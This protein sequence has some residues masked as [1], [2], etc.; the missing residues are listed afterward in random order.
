[1]PKDAQPDNYFDS[2]YSKDVLGGEEK[3]TA[4]QFHFHA[5]SEHTI[6][7]KRYDLEMHTVHAP[8]EAKGDPVKIKYSAVGLMFDTENFD[9]SISA[10]DRATIDDFFDSLNFSSIPAPGKAKGHVMAAN[11]EVPFGDLMKMVNFA[12]RWVYTGS[13]TTPPCTVGVYF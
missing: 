10:A 6:D 5:K 12:N 2:G 4:L 7:G 13:L 11:T 1:M 3:F 9:T 8:D